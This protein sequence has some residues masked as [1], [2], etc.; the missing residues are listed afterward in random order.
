MIPSSDCLQWSSDQP[1]P[2]RKRR[3]QGR[4]P[5]SAG[6]NPR[7]TRSARSRSNKI[8]NCP[9]TQRLNGSTTVAKT[10]FRSGSSLRFGLAERREAHSGPKVGPIPSRFCSFEG[11]S[12]ATKVE[13]RFVD[14][15]EPPAVDACSWALRLY[16]A[17]CVRQYNPR[18]RLAMIYVFKTLHP[19]LRGAGQS[20]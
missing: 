18:T 15:P 17:C 6:H 20:C 4:L 9:P 19:G 2:A 1:G 3:V 7:Q 5:Q 10:S 16:L 8:R 14:Q 12:C 11:A 13:D